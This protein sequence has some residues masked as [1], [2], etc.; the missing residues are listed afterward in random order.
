M[1]FPYHPVF[2]SLEDNSDDAAELKK[3][4]VLL[5]E[6]NKQL[7]QELQKEKSRNSK[8]RKNYKEFVKDNQ[9]A[10]YAVE[11][12]LSCMR[13][14]IQRN[15][16][17]FIGKKGASRSAENPGSKSPEI[18]TFP[19][20]SKDLNLDLDLGKLCGCQR[21]AHSQALDGDPYSRTIM[22][23]QLPQAAIPCFTEIIRPGIICPG[24]CVHTPDGRC[25][26]WRI[27]S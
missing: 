5:K 15:H 26:L 11:K 14:F 12:K 13:G 10:L 2:H 9:I 4:V 7:D 24:G 21:S 23:H 19:D 8:Y 20:S 22:S 25:K 16:E 17:Q 27:P 6:K 18:V 3:E 1:N